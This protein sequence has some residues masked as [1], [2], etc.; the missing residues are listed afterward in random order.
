VYD[1]AECKKLATTFSQFFIQ[2]IHQI[3]GNIA[4]ALQSS[5]RRQFA[6][7]QHV[8]P[9]L[10]AFQPVTTDEVQRL[11]SRMPAKSSTYCRAR[12]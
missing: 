7:K 6:I 3:R 4:S 5:M 12:C 10:A 1:D 8:G 9:T 2:K 11:L